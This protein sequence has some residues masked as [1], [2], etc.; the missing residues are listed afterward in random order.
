M[1]RLLNHFESCQVRKVTSLLAEA[2]SL[3]FNH[4]GFCDGHKAHRKTPRVRPLR[5]LSG[6][7]LDRRVAFRSAREAAFGPPRR[8]TAG[9][10]R[11]RWRAQLRQKR[12]NYPVDPYRRQ[13]TR[14]VT[15]FPRQTQVRNTSARQSQ[16][17]E[18]GYHQPRPPIRLLGVAHPRRRP[19]HALLQEAEGVLQIEAP[20]VS[21]PE[22]IEVRRHPLRAVPPQPQNARLASPL[23]AGQPLYLHQ[24]ERTDHDGQQSAATLSFVVLDLRVQLR[25][26]AHAH[27]PV[28]GVLADV[29]GGGLGPGSWI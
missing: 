20:D 1:G 22:Q 29:F 21:A 3:R 25:E 27:P 2:L 23:A 5:G 15:A 28:S 24:N 7:L 10:R 16:L 6:S 11:L 18:G 17:G 8:P 13:S 19:S 26:G 12:R 4:E 14:I 9:F